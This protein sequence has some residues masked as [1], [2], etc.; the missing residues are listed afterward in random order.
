[1]CRRLQTLS[2]VSRSRGL[3]L[4]LRSLGSKPH[5]IAQSMANPKLVL[6]GDSILDNEPYTRPKPSTTDHLTR[7]LPHWSVTRVAVD[8]STMADV[9]SQ[10]RQLDGQPNV[11]VLSVGGNDAVEHISLLNQPASSSAEVLQQLL[12]I[13]DDFAER[14]EAVV[15]SLTQKAER[16]LLCT[17]YEV[18][19]EP[20]VFAELAR[21]PLSLLNDR[22][23]R[24]GS[25]LSVD[26]LDLRSV[27]TD[28][29]DFVL[30]IEPSSRGAEK[31]A[32]A[33][34]ALVAEKA[35]L[36]SARVFAA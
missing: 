22:I 25:R 32:R 8:G 10:L 7:L 5:I 4:N 12:E 11:A 31:I 26:V 33:I 29:A 27:C 13:A 28:P 6:I 15:R 9:P 3:Q 17:I 18:Q 30:Q 1:M 16:V 24:I 35:Q 20:A 34:A 21:V 14:Y 23:I 19:L 2:R 36:R